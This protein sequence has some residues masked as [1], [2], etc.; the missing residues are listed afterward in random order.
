MYPRLV[1]LFLVLALGLAVTLT[2]VTTP[3]HVSHRPS[4]RVGL[5]PS[6]VAGLKIVV[7]PPAAEE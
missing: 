4:V 5:F 3:R 2:T 7:L 1:F 6:E